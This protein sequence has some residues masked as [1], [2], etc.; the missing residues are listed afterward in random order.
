M[1]KNVPLPQRGKALPSPQYAAAQECTIDLT[2]ARL[3]DVVVAAVAAAALDADA[4]DTV[5]SLGTAAI[6]ITYSVPNLFG[7]TF[8]A[9]FGRKR[10]R[11]CVRR[12]G[13]WRR[14][15]EVRRLATR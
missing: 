1:C 11:E 12:C 2:N 10:E 4:A 13:R 7:T 14:A 9:L 5:T 3:A 15:I 6:S 8:A